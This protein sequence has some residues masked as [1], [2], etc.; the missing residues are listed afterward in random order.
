[1]RLTG[2]FLLTV[3]MTTTKMAFCF[4]G[5]SLVAIGIGSALSPA[6]FSRSRLCV[7][8]AF[9]FSRSS[10]KTVLVL[11]AVHGSGEVTLGLF[12]AVDRRTSFVVSAGTGGFFE[13][14]RTFRLAQMEMLVALG[15]SLDRSAFGISF[16]GMHV[17]GV[18]GQ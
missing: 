15:L 18:H 11:F 6:A 10:L 13:A 7:F 16:A 2:G 8:L 9:E 5:H 3:A 17:F 1:L 4:F 12:A 14:G